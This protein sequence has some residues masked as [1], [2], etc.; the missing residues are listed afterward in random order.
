MIKVN[1][2]TLPNGLRVLVSPSTAT[3]SVTVMILVRAGSRYESKST[4]GIAHVLEHMFFKGGDK[5]PTPRA[6]AEAIESIGGSFNAFTGNEK[7]GYYVKVAS[8]KVETAFD[9]LSDM[10]FHAQLS[11][12]ALDREKGVILEELKMYLDDPRHLASEAFSHQIFGDHPLGWDIIGTP[13]NIKSFTSQ[14][15]RNYQAKFYSSANTVVAVAGNITM[16]KVKKLIA[17]YLPYQPSKKL[18]HPLPHKAANTASFKHVIKDTEQ[19]HLLIGTKT[20]GG[21]NKDRYAA[22]LLGTI[23]GGGMSSRL[24]ASVREELSLAY[25]VGAGHQ[26]YT[27]TGYFVIQAGVD[28]TRV[29]LAIHQIMKELRE[30]AA[31]G[32]SAI[33]LK[34]AQEQRIGNL[35]LSLEVSDEIAYYL[36]LKWLLYGEVTTPDSVK[37]QLKAVKP[38]DIQRLAK[39]FFTASPLTLTVVGPKTISGKIKESYKELTN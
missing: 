13:Q 37:R 14:D 10:L 6:V 34:K 16:A 15:L 35:T 7:V 25:Y 17:K 29:D 5:Y 12:E 39:K 11:Q 24:F 32:V 1:K 4:N 8:H 30:I 20:F 21:H 36:G 38:Q 27:D 23:L 33:E 18:N 31:N 19:A 2:T 22:A 3:D 28:K 26:T 9:V